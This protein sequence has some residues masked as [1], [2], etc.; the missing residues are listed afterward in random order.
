MLAN[1]ALKN[2]VMLF[3]ERVCITLDKALDKGGVLSSTKYTEWGFQTVDR[4]S[5]QVI[6]G[7]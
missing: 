7:F 6:N 5:D 4:V 1:L 3:E 2:C